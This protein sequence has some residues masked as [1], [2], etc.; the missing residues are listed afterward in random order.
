[1]PRKNNKPVTGSKTQHHKKVASD[2]SLFEQE[3]LIDIAE[4]RWSLDRSMGVRGLGAVYLASNKTDEPVGSDAQHVVIVEP[5]QNGHLFM[6]INSYRRMAKSDMTDQWRRC[7][8]M[9]HKGLLPYIGSGSHVC[10]GEKCRFLV[11]ERCGQDIDKLFLQSGR[12]FSVKTAFYIGKQILDT[13]EYIHSIGYTHAD[14]KG[15][16]PVLGCRKGAENCVYIIDF[17]ILCRY[18][19]YL[20]TKR[21]AMQFRPHISLLQNYFVELHEYI[22]SRVPCI[23]SS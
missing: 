19:D 10:R 18:L 5:H 16:S 23:K 11:Q 13:L 4:N 21:M 8:K 20:P 2:D 6:E 9:K 7:R 17:D 12:K 14:M 15:P 3:I 22:A 1:M